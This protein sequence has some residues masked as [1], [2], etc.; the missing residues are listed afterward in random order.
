M[1]KAIQRSLLIRQ[2]IPEVAYAF[3]ASRLGEEWEQEYGTLKV[4]GA[5]LKKIVDRA[6]IK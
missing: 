3:C 2:S 4:N 6:A 1:A 5:P